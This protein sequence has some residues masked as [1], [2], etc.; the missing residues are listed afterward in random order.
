MN[1][2]YLIAITTLL[3]NSCMQQEYT[4]MEYEFEKQPVIFSNFNN[5]EPMEVYAHWTVSFEEA[6]SLYPQQGNYQTP[7]A[8]TIKDAELK[9]FENNKYIAS[10]YYVDSIGCYTNNSLIPKI[11]YRYKMEMDIPGYENKVLA[12]SYVPEKVEIIEVVPNTIPVINT[13][14][15]LREHLMYLE[16]KPSSYKK[17]LSLYSSLK[18]KK[19]NDICT[20]RYFSIIE[21]Q[22]EKYNSNM[23]FM[24]EVYNGDKVFFDDRYFIGNKEAIKMASWSLSYT[25]FEE[26]KNES[27]CFREDPKAYI[28]METLSSDLYLYYI[29]IKPGRYSYGGVE[30][31]DLVIFEAT[32]DEEIYSNIEGGVGVF[33]GYSIS[34]YPIEFEEL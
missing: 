30:S 28:F 2:T 14:N 20:Y 32:G 10:L 31:P 26:L 18:S 3:L 12:E 29:T 11:G 6:D 27:S 23:V 13:E 15:Q 5:T 1:K 24:Q 21:M 17:Y 22:D 34:T 9:I 33:G 7:M 25:K 16:A 8:D 19:V 4:L